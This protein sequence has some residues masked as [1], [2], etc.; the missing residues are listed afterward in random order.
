VAPPGG[1]EGKGVHKRGPSSTG[2]VPGMPV[3][4]PGGGRRAPALEA[5][6]RMPGGRA[7][8]DFLARDLGQPAPGEGYLL[9]SFCLRYRS[10]WIG[11]PPSPGQPAADELK[12]PGRIIFICMGCN[13][14]V[15]APTVQ[16]RKTRGMGACSPG[17]C[18]H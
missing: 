3:G 8:A 13:S 18:Q 10:G 7:L 1:G 16:G 11:G 6:L 5:A 9:G 15:N 17:G 12:E 4:S 14:F 2:W